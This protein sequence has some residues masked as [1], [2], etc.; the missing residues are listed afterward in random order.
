MYLSEI[1]L[2]PGQ[3]GVVIAAT[4]IGSAMLTIVVGFATPDL[5]RRTVLRLMS[6]LMVL[7]G[8][9]FALFHEFWPIVVVALV[10]TLNPSGGDI[11]AFQPTEQAM[12]SG[13]VSDERRTAIFAR[14]ALV[15]TLVVAIGAALAVV[16]D[17]I[18]SATSV[19]E[20]AALRATFLGYAVVGFVV[21]VRY[22]SLSAA[23][24]PPPMKRGQAL[25]PSRS[26]VYR[27]AAL[28]SL[29]SFGGGFTVTAIIVLWLQQRFDLSLAVSGSVFFWAGLLAAWSQLLAPTLARRIGLVRTMAFTHIPA[30]VFLI[31]AAVMPTAW[32]AIGCLLARAALSQMDAPARTSY[33]MAV[34]TPEER[35]AAASLTNVPRS[36]AAALPPLAAGWLLSRSDIGLPLILG[37]T[38]KIVY[39]VILLAQFRHV[40][41]PEEAR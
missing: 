39:D 28:F 26:I 5:T 16:P 41:P 6:V 23:A 22:G 21:L 31:L 32:L 24:E 25:G 17:R 8:V 36:F 14:H 2:S 35:P 37:G 4:M 29:D 12:L 20:V 38:I 11:S 34:V 15:G 18:A 33:V 10:G 7:T 13:T 3:I 1:G 19:T 40:R 9:G 27:L 30:N